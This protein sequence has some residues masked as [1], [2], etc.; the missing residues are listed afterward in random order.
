VRSV[1][2]LAFA[3]WGTFL[4]V[5]FP[6]RTVRRRS[7]F[8]DAARIDRSRPRP[9]AWMLADALFL[10]GSTLVLAGP[11]LQGFGVLGAV[12]APG[13]MLEIFAVAL[14]A[15]ATALVIWAQETMGVA[16]R[17][18]IAPADR[19][20]LVTSGP[21]AVIRNPSY[22]AMALAGLGTLLLA[23]TVCTVGGWILML[24]GLAI[25][26]R[27]EE[28][29]LAATYGQSYRDYAADTGRFLPFIGRL[30]C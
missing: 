7:Q 8:G 9:P 20:H 30:R 19:A 12:F 26:T 16:W 24:A 1:P 25:T 17:T 28:P 14:T 11:A 18:D 10:V 23:P 2:W 5:V 27:A 21:F 3:L 29:Q 15:G 6:L 13:R 4:I 22:V